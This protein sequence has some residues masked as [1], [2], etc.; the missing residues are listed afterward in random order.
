MMPPTSRSRERERIERIVTSVEWPWLTVAMVYRVLRLP[1]HR[2]TRAMAQL[3]MRMF[4]AHG[5]TQM[6]NA[7]SDGARERRWLRTSSVRADMTT[8]VAHLEPSEV[9]A[10]LRKVRKMMRGSKQAQRTFGLDYSI[11]MAQVDQALARHGVARTDEQQQEV[12]T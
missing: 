7:G 1:E 6:V 12:T 2:R 3:I 5:Y 10:L 4:R 11:V 9:I 8:S